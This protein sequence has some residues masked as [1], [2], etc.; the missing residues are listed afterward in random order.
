MLGCAMNV[1]SLVVPLAL[2]FGLAAQGQPLDRD[3]ATLPVFTIGPNGTF[4]GRPALIVTTRVQWS[5]GRLRIEG[6]GGGP[7]DLV[8]GAGGSL[9]LEDAE[10]ELRGDVRLE[11]GSDL[12]LRRLRFSL[13]NSFPRE[14]NFWWNGGRL[15]TERVS[16]GGSLDAREIPQPANFWL[17]DGLWTAHDTVVRDSYGIVVDGGCLDATGLA[18]GRNADAVI[19]VSGDATLRHSAANVKLALYPTSASTYD[20]DLP[21]ETLIDRVYGDQTVHDALFRRPVTKHLPGSPWRL[22]LFQTKV[23]L[24]W[25][26]VQNVSMTGPPVTVT[27]RDAQAVVLRVNANDLV[28]S[29]V[30]TGPW[31]TFYPLPHVLP[32]LPAA[33][34][35]GEHGI[36]PGCGVRLGNVTFQAPSNDWAYPVSWDISLGARS[37]F[38]IRGAARLTEVTLF[39]A[40]LTLEGLASYEAGIDAVTLDLDGASVAT[41]RNASVGSKGG[42]QPEI[43]ARGG[44]VCDLQNVVASNLLLRTAPGRAGAWAGVD[45][46]RIT[47]RDFVAEGSLTELRSSGGTISV[48]RA[49]TT[50][51]FDL[52]NLDFERGVRPDGSAEY[53]NGTNVAGYRSGQTGPAARGVASFGYRSTAGS[54]SI[55]KTL[56][57][58][59]G[60]D[61]ELFGW[62]RVLQAT[63]GTVLTMAI[64]GASGGNSVVTLPASAGGFAYFRVPSYRVR[65]N[66]TIVTIRFGHSSSSGTLDVLLDDFGVPVSR[67]WEVDNLGNLAFEDTDFLELGPA[68]VGPGRWTLFG[69]T[70]AAEF[71][72][73][74]PGAGPGTRATRIVATTGFPIL[75]KDL[76]DLVPGQTIAVSGWIKGLPHGGGAWDVFVRIGESN[77]CWWDKL[78]GNNVE[79]VVRTGGWS[80]FNLSYVVPQP[81]LKEYSTR[82]ALSWFVPGSTLLV[83][84]FTVYIR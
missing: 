77:E 28:G 50:Q 58:R 82:F 43:V 44:S 40:K 39:D 72:D 41:I 35:P 54:G 11:P 62:I 51:D 78:Y 79:Q 19:M 32:D 61:V 65:P 49:G 25:V 21:R 83:D 56:A 59:P 53:W 76:P 14:F 2:F 1:A 6:P 57:L 64:D 4:K 45:R 31:R 70:A 7:C 33:A 27:L 60:V 71:A 24:W 20:L 47:L 15:L 74:R 73:L 29:P 67:R 9:L 34:P 18:E 22:E 37:D 30:L 3:R 55:R 17:T 23:A 8:I 13:L 10:V 16:I 52:T 26:C 5:S 48:A 80:Q 84:D 75:S 46:G 36:P 68:P 66:D 12:Q 42:S 63:P 81:P 38:T 69:A